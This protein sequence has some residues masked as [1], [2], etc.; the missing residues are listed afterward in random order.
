MMWI[1]PGE[2]SLSMPGQAASADDPPVA[3]AGFWLGQSEVTAGQYAKVMRT[4]P[5]GDPE[6]AAANLS[7]TDAVAFCEALTAA[8][9]AA[10][11]LPEGLVYRLPYEVE[12]E[13]AAS[14]GPIRFRR[15]NP[16]PAAT[17]ATRLVSVD[18]NDRSASTGPGANDLVAM[19]A[20]VKE[21][22]LDAYQPS[23]AETRAPT[24]PPG[25]KVVRGGLTGPDLERA[26]MRFGIYTEMDRL[27]FVG[28]RVALG[29][30]TI[31]QTGL[32]PPTPPLEDGKILT[33]EELFQNSP[34]ADWGSHNHSLILK[35]A[36]KAFKELSLYDTTVDGAS[37]PST[38]KAINQYQANNRL[39]IS[40]QL[41]EA[42]LKAL[43]LMD[44]TKQK[45]PPSGPWWETRPSYPRE[46]D[47]EPPKS[48]YHYMGRIKL[49]SDRK[50]GTVN[51]AELRKYEIYERWEEK[52]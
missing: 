36:Q 31:Q 27:P 35:K 33:R 25:A 15:P 2:Y 18:S 22:C 5:Q 51:Q 32:A 46:G 13:F 8:E 30:P 38:Q 34:Y 23:P 50:K 6:A 48:E 4:T 24:P 17:W 19:T 1:A 21:W 12:W 43:Q 44:E 52:Q 42:T 14:S 29:S 20:G 16:H 26:S 47:P 11:R 45:A 40:G 3:V 41:D 49:A 7:W 37:G 28:F 9:Q 10:G 39:P